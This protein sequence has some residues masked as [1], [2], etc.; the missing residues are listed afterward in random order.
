MYIT[1][2]AEAAIKGVS[3]TFTETKHM[4][5]HCSHLFDFGI[6]LEPINR[7]FLNELVKT[8]FTGTLILLL[9]T[10]ET[11]K[12]VMCFNAVKVSF[13]MCNSNWSV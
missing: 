8:I 6:A 2:R 5:S 10:H 4:T 11:K 13:W 12:L 9:N 3:M 7:S 1:F